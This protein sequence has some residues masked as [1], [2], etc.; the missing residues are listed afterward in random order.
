MERPPWSGP[1]GAPT[2]HASF[3]TPAFFF[4]KDCTLY[5]GGDG[6]GGAGAG[7]GAG[8][9][10]SSADVAGAPAGATTHI[11]NGPWFAG[12]RPTPEHSLT[13]WRTYVA[14]KKC[15]NSLKGKEV[16]VHIILLSE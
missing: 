5:N 7:R 12:V 14:H 16:R 3:T 8:A 1:R 13:T 9:A 10:H 4:S 15:Y 11:R 2:G 6:V